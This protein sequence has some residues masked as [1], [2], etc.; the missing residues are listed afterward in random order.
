MVVFVHCTYKYTLQLL[1]D[2]FLYRGFHTSRPLIFLEG[3][4]HCKYIK[5]GAGI[6]N[7]VF[8]R[9]Y[10]IGSNCIGSRSAGSNMDSPS[11]SRSKSTKGRVKK[12]KGKGQKV[13]K[14][15]QHTKF[16]YDL[17]RKSKVF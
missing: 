15:I 2:F 9:I 4:V 7:V 6:H 3:T 10:I 12:Y 8:G 13:L 11:P 14:K 16:N 17:R 1:L 5:E